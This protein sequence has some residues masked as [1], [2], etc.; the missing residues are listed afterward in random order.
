MGGILASDDWHSGG[1][2]DF[3]MGSA[4][5]DIGL[6][7]PKQMSSC[8]GS[9]RCCP[10]TVFFPQVPPLPNSFCAIAWPLHGT[11]E[12]DIDARMTL[13]MHARRGHRS[14]RAN[15]AGILMTDGP[16]DQT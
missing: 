15:S 12:T 6:A 16:G 13:S 7:E 8:V 11:I 3:V 9:M 14:T 4:D 5:V 1:A 2:E 10:L